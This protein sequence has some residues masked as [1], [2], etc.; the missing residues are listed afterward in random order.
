[1]R[2]YLL[3]FL[4]LTL[5]LLACPVFTVSQ[6]RSGWAYSLTVMNV[7]EHF[8]SAVQQR[9]EKQVK[10]VSLTLIMGGWCAQAWSCFA[11]LDIAV[12]HL[13]SSP[14]T[15]EDIVAKLSLDPCPHQ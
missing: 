15:L 11:C 2:G 7:N 13:L 14:L 8:D 12:V 5:P 4:Y 3:C 9:K 6:A 1:M 10:K